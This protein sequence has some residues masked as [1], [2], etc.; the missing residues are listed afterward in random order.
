MKLVDQNFKEKVEE[1]IKNYPHVEVHIQ[2]IHHEGIEPAY[3]INV[4]AKETSESEK[5]GYLGR[6]D[7]YAV[8]DAESMNE[9]KKYFKSQENVNLY[10]FNI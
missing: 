8:A 2:Q 6:A 1:T 5:W 10:E 3:L 9:W 7:A 4:Y